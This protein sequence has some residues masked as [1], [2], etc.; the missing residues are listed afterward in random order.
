MTEYQF[1]QSRKPLYLATVASALII[2]AA[3]YIQDRQFR[4]IDYS[5]QSLQ[6]TLGGTLS[7]LDSVLD[8]AEHLTNNLE[9]ELRG[10]KRDI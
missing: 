7:D 5:L 3:V 1:W 9:G 10:L 8:R 2:G 4:K 6:R